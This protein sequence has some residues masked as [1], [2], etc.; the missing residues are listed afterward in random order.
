MR[1]CFEGAHSA[2]KSRLANS[3]RRP[4]QRGPASFTLQRDDGL[5]LLIGGLG[6]DKLRGSKQDD[7]LI[8]VH[9]LLDEYANALAPFR[10]ELSAR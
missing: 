6:L 3:G 2:R 1:K 5:D 10:A 4:L 9:T 8:G 7:V